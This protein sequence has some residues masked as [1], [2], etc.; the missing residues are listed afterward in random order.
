MRIGVRSRGIG[1][2]TRRC[3]RQQERASHR[4]R[5][6]ETVA[7]LSRPL[8]L[9]REVY[10]SGLGFRFDPPGDIQGWRSLRTYI[11]LGL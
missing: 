7:V 8:L 11:A 9:G 4:Y 3:P 10:G 2:R 1:N 5:L 6:L